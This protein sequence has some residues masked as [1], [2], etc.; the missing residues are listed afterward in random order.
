MLKNLVKNYCNTVKKKKITIFIIFLFNKFKSR[1]LEQILPLC[2]N[3]TNNI[4]L[5][6]GGKGMCDCQEVPFTLSKIK[7]NVSEM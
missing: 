6:F 2:K 1:Y 5:R 3:T 7:S 4:T